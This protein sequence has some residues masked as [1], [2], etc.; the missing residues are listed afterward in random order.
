VSVAIA[1]WILIVAAAGGG[2]AAMYFLLR[3]SP[4]K[5][6]R[7]LLIGS[8]LGVFLLPAPVPGFPGHIAPA[9]VVAIFEMFMQIDGK[10]A[11]A[12]RI[13]GLGLLAIIG[14]ILAF[15]R[16]KLRSKPN[17]GVGD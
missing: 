13:L 4:H 15:H 14:L 6:I 5:L 3:A 2:A 1:V 17:A 7:D 11:V 12:L 9:F 16:L 8:M 10:P